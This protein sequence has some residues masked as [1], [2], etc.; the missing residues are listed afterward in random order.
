[1]MNATDMV[2]TGMAGTKIYRKADVTGVI[3]AHMF[4]DWLRRAWN[5]ISKQ[6]YI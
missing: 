6:V 2:E 5:E 1:M 3:V 4:S